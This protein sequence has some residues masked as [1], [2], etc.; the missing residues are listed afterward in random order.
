MFARKTK[1]QIV[2]FVLIAAVGITYTGS[3]YAG[4]D[5]VFGNSGYVVR[6]QLADSGGVFT[7]A[8]V[9]YRGVPVGR[10]GEMELTD[11]GVEVQLDLENGGPSIP[12]GTSAVVANR[13]AVGE[14]YVDLVPADE[15]PPYLHAGSVIPKERTTLPPRPENVLTNLDGLAKSVPTDS[16]RTV[17]DEGD[18]AFSDTGPQ[19]QSLLDSTNS[20]TNQAREHLPQT[21]QLLSNGRTVLRTQQQDAAQITDFS[22]GLNKISGQLKDSDPDVRNVIDRAPQVSDQVDEVLRESGPQMGVMM[23]NLLT[24]TQVMTNRTDAVEQMLVALPV[25]TSLTPGMADENDTGHLSYILANYGNPLPCTKGYEG[26]R[27]RGADDQTSIPQN[28]EA[29]CAEPPGSPIGVRGSQNAPPAPEPTA[30]PEPNLTFPPRA[31]NPQAGSGQV[32]YQNQP[33][34]AQENGSPAPGL[35]RAPVPGPIGLLD[36]GGSPRT[37]AQL[38]GLPG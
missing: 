16:L 17:L 5:R 22:A 28:H 3:E 13:S 18:K 9:T 4:L 34:Q 20:V 1:I 33:D 25:M 27:G 31:G 35:G 12:A 10:V 21:K 19:L 37:F 8:E 15:K 7:N 14:Q 6:L 23:A 38:L 2:L 32:G 29:H 30:V 36:P 11:D 24:T 26:T